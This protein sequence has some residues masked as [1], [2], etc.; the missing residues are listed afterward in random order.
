[1]KILSVTPKQFLAVFLLSLFSCTALAQGAISNGDS[2]TG[3]I[4]PIGNIDQWTFSANAGESILVQVAE[5]SGT[6]FQPFLRLYDPLGNEISSNSGNT[7][8]NLVSQAAIAG[9]YTIEVLDAT[10]TPDGT[11]N[12]QLYLYVAGSSFTVPAGDE[13]GALTNGGVHAGEIE[14]AD[15]D[16]WSFNADALDTVLIQVGEVT[17]ASGFQPY[18][19]L[20]DADGN[21]IADNSGNSATNLNVQLSE[22]GQHTVVVREAS[23]DVESTGTYNLYFT[24]VGQSFVVPAGDEGGVLTNGGVHAGEIELAD[25][26]AWSFNADALDTVL[27]QVGEV[28]GASGFQPY[29]LLYDADGNLIA[30]N[31]G[32]SATNLNVQLSEGGQ[33]TVVVREASSDV[34]STGTYNLYF[35]NVGQSFV[36]P[37]GDEGGALTNGGVHAGEI[38]LADID[39]WSIEVDANDQINLSIV[40]T[41]DNGGFEPFILLYDTFGRLLASDSGSTSASLSVF[42]PT[43]G[44]YIIAVRE[45]S[46]DVESTGEYDLSYNMVEDGST[47]PSG[48]VLATLSNGGVV[49]GQFAG[50]TDVDKFDLSLTAGQHV[51]LQAGD[52][53]ST[54]GNSPTINVF[55]PA[56]NLMSADSSGSVAIS[57]FVAPAS[58]TY[59]VALQ[60]AVTTTVTYDYALHTAI[61]QQAFVVPSGDEGGVLS[62][63]DIATG[64][65]SVA[66]LDLYSLAV[67]VGDEVRLQLGDV[68]GSSG[69]TPALQVYRA[70]GSLLAGN[71]Q[72]SVANTSFIADADETLTVVV[73]ND[74]LT[75]VSYDYALHTAISQ[76]AFVVPSGDEGGVLSNGDIAT[77]TLSVADLD[78]YSL[79]VNAGDE[80]RLRLGDVSGSSG[81]TPALQVYRADGSLLAGNTQGS[82][83][84]TSFIADADETLTVV[85]RNDVL[86]TVSYDYALHTAISQQAFVVPSGD[87]GGVLSNGDI[88]TGT[89]SVADLDLYSL[90]VNAGDEVRLRLGDVSGSSGHTPAL[91]VYRADGSLLAGNAQGSVAN[92]SFIA[93]AD[94]TLTVVVRN[95]VLTTVSYNYALHTAVSQQGFGVPAG[96]QGGILNN[97]VTENGTTTVAD[98]DL[99]SLSVSSGDS[100]TISVTDESS[101]SGHTPAF[102]VFQ[103]NGA[104]VAFASGSTTASISFESQSD[105]ALFIVV[106]NNVSTT[107][108]YDYSILATGTNGVAD[109]DNDGL[110]D[111]DEVTNSTN[112]NLPDSD[113]DAINDGDEVNSLGTDP[114]NPDTDGDDFDDGTEVLAGSDPLDPNS[115]PAVNVPIL[116]W[117]PW[118]VGLL[119][120]YIVLQQRKVR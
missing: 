81:H 42:A 119:T 45:A 112:I 38:E 1:M 41:L 11:A 14:L 36:V 53:S 91:Q 88:A 75:T 100:I 49:S 46:S 82:V 118:I 116:P 96:D 13:G 114:L 30:D 44:S 61:S 7:A 99:Y 86:T 8:T 89:L 33:H 74:V 109:T 60:N 108:S 80:V 115:T 22:G 92:T 55:S 5:L 18:L 117:A 50:S 103:A 90:A 28:T 52:A 40:E 78:L 97:N 24:N 94:E 70:D 69:H 63:G 43:K 105:Q 110:S 54:S 79:A 84:N 26:D 51:R 32:N 12:Y 95:D 10:A 9:T 83:A 68:S 47:V 34:E 71:A 67:N 104:L 39:T 16:A 113:G 20:Y 76:Q 35:T 107:A 15:I 64:T 85:V 25:I 106:R 77:G 59:T 93:D 65:L 31:S 72:S 73:R 19:L 120:V 62:N 101:S 66:D 87:E 27:I 111:F 21:L 57:N 98:L 48:S 29:L 23:S 4:S 37:A 6:N 102:E 2:P 17:G 3:S 56:G 58:G